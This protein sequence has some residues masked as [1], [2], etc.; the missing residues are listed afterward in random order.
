MYRTGDLVWWGA[1]GQLRYLGRCDEQVKIRGYRIE[2]GEVQAALAGLDGVQQAVVIARED[3]PGDKRLVGY[4][5][6]AVDPVAVR[7]AVAQRLPGYMVPVAVVWVDS[8]PM[9]VNGKL[10]TR[11]LPAPEYLDLD[12]YRAPGSAVEEILAGIYAQVLGLE[13]VGVD[14]SFFE[15]GGDS[16][17][18]MR[19]IAAV[20]TGLDASLAVHTVFEAPTVAELAPLICEDAGRLE[21]L[22]AVERPA[23][24]PLSYAQQRLWLLDQW[25]GPSPVYNMV[26]ALR[27]GGHLDVDALVAALADVVGRQ[28]SLHTLVVAPDGIPQQLLVPPGQADFGWDFG[29]EI[30]DATGWSAAQLDEAVGDAVRYT[31]NLA[32]EI[33]LRAKLFRLGEDEHV[34]VAVLHHIAADGWSVAPLLAD[35][36]VAYTSRCAGELPNWVPLPVQ[37]VDYTLWQRRLLGDLTSSEGPIAAQLA[38]WEQALAGLP[39]RLELPTDRPYPAVADQRGA[40]AAVAWPAQLQQQIA[41]VARAHN[42]TSFMVVQAA[43]AVLLSKLSASTDVAVGFAIAGRSDPAL[44][45]LVGF[46]VNTLVLRVDLA[47]DPTVDELLAQVRQR[48]L[49]AYEHQDVP[50]EVLVERLN[51]TRSLTHHPLFQVALG[52]QNNPP[53]KLALGDLEVT[54]VP[55]DTRTARMDMTFA[56]AERFTEAGEPAGIDGAVEFRTDVFDADSIATLIER[57]ERVLAGI[58]ADPTARLSSI[59]VLDA[60][61]HARLEEIGNRAVLNGPAAA[62]APVSVPALFAEHVLRTPEAVAVSARERSWTYRELDDAATRLAHRLVGRGAGPGHCVALLLERSAEAI[63]SILAALK[64]GAAYLPIDVSLP[65][66]RI[67]FILADAAPVV[68]IT[69][70]ELRSRLDGFG[71]PVIDVGDAEAPVADGVLPTPGPDDIAYVIYTSGTTGVPKGVAITHHNMTQLLGSLDAGLP[72]AGVWPLCHSLAFDVSVWEIFGPLLR[73]GRV[74]VVPEE[75][76]GSPEDFHALLVRERVNVLTQTP[77]AVRILPPEGLESA[78]L[79]VVGEACP[80]EVVE[81]WAPGRV[82]INAYGPTETTMCVAISAPLTPGSGVPIGSPVSGAALF[83]LDQWLQPVPAGVVGELYVAGQGVG[84]GYVGQ[85]DLTASRFVACPF[86]GAGQPGQRM[87]RTGDLVCWRPDGQ[88]QYFGRADEQVKIRGYRVE[89][90]EVQ[91][92]LAGIDGVEQAAVIAREDRPGALRVVGYVTGTVTGTV[93]GTVEPT[94]IRTR[95]A[96][97][98]PSYMVPA[99]VVVLDEL[100]LTTNGKLDVRALPAPEYTP[101]EHRAPGSTI[102]KI[103]SDAYAEV[104]GVDWVGVDDSFFDLGGDSIMSMQV[105]TRARAAGVAFRPRD[106]FVEQTVARLARVATVADDASGVVDEGIGPVPATPIISWLHG[107]QRA[108]GPIDEFNQTVVVQA[109][110][111]VTEADVLVVLQALL[112]RHAMLR[113]RADDLGAQG[114]EGWSLTVPEVGAVVAGKCLHTVDVLA[115]EALVE[116]RS[117]LDPAAGVMLSALWVASARQLVVIVHHL[118]IDGVSWR[119]LLED[120][121]IAWAQHHDGQP[122]ALPAGG[123]SFARWASLL[124]EYARRPEV[125]EQAEAW[126][127]VA[128]TPAALPA[129]Q[130]A[131]DTYASAGQL[132]VSLDAA[133]TQT[134]LGEVPAAFHA[135]IQDILLIAFALAVREFL[136]AGTAPIGIDVEGHGRIEDLGGAADLDLSRTVGWFT[137]KYPVSLNFGGQLGGQLRAPSGGQGWA[138][139]SWAQVMG[140]DAA[141]GPVIKAAKEQLLNLSDPLSYGVLRYLNP[142][143]DLAVPE[144]VIGFNYLGRLGAGAAVSDE[145]WVISQD[146]VSLTGAAA[147]VPMPLA[148]TV[149]LNAVTLDSDAGPQ[150]RANWTWAPSVLTHAHVSRLS[151]LWFEALTGI[152]AHVQGGGGGLTPSDIAVSLNQ[153]QID[154]LQRQYADR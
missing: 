35:L 88:L 52:W 79:V 47:G 3:R 32:T 36:G 148:H 93:P 25:Q 42:A 29:W 12:R 113:L 15:L 6:G 109:P 34:L 95:L 101:R 130:P 145:L 78:A 90:G 112:D 70:A 138:G 137:T 136:G 33:P 17:S 54:Q 133:S 77:S 38:Y 96:E 147:A 141:L 66:A 146:G 75:L 140:G 134:L 23:V 87:Y 72:A 51:P 41:R 117:R 37:Y 68:A 28:Q 31:F 40:T 132:S 53:A 49:E 9:T 143:V 152:C 108:G 5:T 128:A 124:N 63:V 120:L 119:I 107:V 80:P 7:A 144:P 48:G 74:V 142:D 153:Q 14:D 59:G 83:V 62:F 115:E 19:L 118:A 64:T 99:A 1:D 71:V 55:V 81:Q 94:R 45:E 82:M 18:A 11:A 46:F 98:L 121:N 16:L 21:P 154:E 10:D 139:L 50:F 122:V 58:T 91:A 76:A 86:V 20:N 57:L 67:E 103:L 2:L 105:V 125:V 13:R 104:L 126:R 56:F 110:A 65:A 27:L 127:Q 135:G 4:V 102:E 123:T 43:L 61:E 24:V 84:V 97:R 116:A 73:G 129:V 111:G 8:L 92:A 26:A 89:L 151:R 60:A 100:P 106:I 85:A 150:L 69:T 114:A 22:L 30:V 44:D 149:A 39:E 131:V